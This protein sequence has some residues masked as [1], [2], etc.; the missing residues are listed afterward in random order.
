[1]SVPTGLESFV[2]KAHARYEMQVRGIMVDEVERVLSSP[3]QVL[4]VRPGRR[5]YQSRLEANEPNKT[6][7]VRVFVDVD[8][9]PAQVVT[10]YRTTKV[11]KYWRR[12]T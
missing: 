11:A 9:D 2:F 7:L 1:M 3:E 6:Y 12:K 4:E 5:V 10:V 8:R